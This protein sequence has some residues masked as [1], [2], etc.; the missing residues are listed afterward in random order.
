MGAVSRFENGWISGS[1][2]FDSLSFRLAPPAGIGSRQAKRLRRRLA[3]LSA[4][5]S[6]GLCSPTIPSARHAQHRAGD[7]RNLEAWPSW[8]GSALLARRRHAARRFESCCLRCIV[9]TSFKRQDPRLLPGGCWFE[10]SRRSSH[11]PVF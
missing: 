1:W 8:K 10:P 7:A 11:A 5:G 3:P 9:A 6:A 4:L 2:G